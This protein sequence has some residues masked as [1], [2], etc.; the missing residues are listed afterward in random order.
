MSFIFK[1][2]SHHFFL[3]FWLVFFLNIKANASESYQHGLSVFSELKY[4]KNFTYFEYVNPHAPK[5]GKIKFGV[6][7]SFN[8][9]NQFILKG[10]NAT[11]ISYIYDSLMENSEDEIMTRY[12][13]IAEAVKIAKDK[14]WIAFKIRKIAKW[15]DENPITADDV[16]FTFNIL[17]K[18]GH[19]SYQMI[20]R[21][22]KEAIKI[23]DHEVKFIFKNNQNRDLPLM[24]ASMQ[25]LP[26]HYYQKINFNQTT[27][28]PPLGSGPYKIKEVIAGKSITYQRVNNYWAK[29]L[30][31]NRG[32]YN[33]DQITFD[34]YRDNNVLIEAF[35][36]QKYDFRQENIA[37][38]W[39]NSY[40]IDAI[41]NGEIIKKEIT[42]NLPSQ[43]QV[44][45]LNLRKTKFQNLALRKAIS[46]AFDFEWLKKHIFY[47]SYQ[48][49][50]SYFS[51]SPFSYQ[52]FKIP[53]SNG[54][55]FNRKNL[56]IATEILKNAGYKIVNQKLIDPQNS[57]PVEIEF[58]IDSPS[59]S[60]VIA[61]FIKN[62]KKL[63]ILAKV[64][65]TEE[66]QYQNRIN[67]F[68][69]DIIIAVF[70]QAMIPGYELFS[71]FHS[72]RKNIKGSS[73]LGGID[74]KEID[75]LIEKILLTKDKN[76]MIKLCKIFDK[77]LL[78]NYYNIPQWQ[79]NSYRILYRDIFNQP[80]KQA[81]YSIALDTW[82]SKDQ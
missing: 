73:N 76:E 33:F 18:E 62:L 48:R 53:E 22:V 17:K 5:G 27:L 61:P 82:W 58:L 32:R 24:I 42:H 52:N 60:M 44:F 20:F 80:K 16:I 2:K 46:Y 13:L 39:H 75:K 35:K 81:T 40:N 41:K 37:R 3:L 55:G 31:V 10:V 72:S 30:P 23:N 36:A 56:I 45:V 43:T 50:K 19:P 71:Y 63:G 9:L 64:R 67:N 74:N 38:N 77:I 78:E 66:N 21:N 26:K 11:G 7:G 79:N 57:K 25:I 54:D 15:H 34:Y 28:E 65:M 47:N 69:F 51:N 29:D 70:G 68:D 4:P 1:I 8:N 14:S 49:T 6:E 59:F 12:G